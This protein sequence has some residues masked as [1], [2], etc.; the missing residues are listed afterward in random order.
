VVLLG[1]Y[2][3]SKTSLFE[4]IAASGG[5][6]R[7]AADREPRAGAVEEQLWTYLGTKSSTLPPTWLLCGAADRLG[8]GHRLLAK[9]LPADKVLTQ[10]GGHDWP[11]WR[12]LWKT[13]C[14]NSALFSDEKAQAAQTDAVSLRDAAR[15][16]GDSIDSRESAQA[17]IRAWERVVAASPE[18][19]EAWVEIGCLRLLEGAAYRTD[20]GERLQCYTAALQACERAMATN[21]EFLQ[22]VRAGQRVRE[23]SAAL[24]ARDM[25]AMHFWSTGIFYIFR[26]CLGLFGRIVNVGKMDDAKALLTRM[27]S[28]DPTWEEHTTT[29]SWGIY[30]LAM[31][32]ARGG[33]KAKARECFDRA[34][35]LGQTRL[36]PR[37]G[38][39][40]YFYPAIGEKQLAK[41]DLKTVTERSLDGLG[42]N[43][44]W[45]RYFQA[46]AARLLKE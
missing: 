24:G 26:D 23:A 15:R 35:A 41:A 20:S 46:E 34:V 43:R 27:D 25:G 4:K 19:A 17:A 5:P 37:W 9:L 6:Q 32:A 29:F 33:D 40:K 11:T 13:V 28:I 30:Y 12:G 16:Q 8:T 7:W 38:R 22:R 1:P 42:G 31:P 18:D 36:L 45:N 10:D 2:L 14:Q 39:G 44:S 21:P 3:G